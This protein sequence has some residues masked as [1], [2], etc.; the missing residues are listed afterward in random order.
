MVG[1]EREGVLK[2]LQ[3][4]AVGS[5]RKRGACVKTL[6]A[7]IP[8]QHVLV[9]AHC[10]AQLH[11]DVAVMLEQHVKVVGDYIPI[12]KTAHVNVVRRRRRA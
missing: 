3:Q 7:I 6:L 1:I 12:D 8:T 2:V 4:S 11:V 10:A 9:H 5:G